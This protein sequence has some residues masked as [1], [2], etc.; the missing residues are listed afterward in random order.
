MKYARITKEDG[1]SQSNN[2]ILDDV[3]DILNKFGI[4][5]EDPANDELIKALTIDKF[6]YARR[7][8]AQVCVQG[9]FSLELNEAYK[10]LDKAM[11]EKIV[12]LG[13]KPIGKIFA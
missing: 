5:N 13:G 11:Q 9:G 2:Y 4:S 3:M 6:E 7:H 10:K 12:E 8:T 1:S